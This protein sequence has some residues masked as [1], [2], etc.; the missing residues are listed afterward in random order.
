MK[1]TANDGMAWM[2]TKAL[3][4]HCKDSRLHMTKD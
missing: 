2:L 4:N 1:V 3:G